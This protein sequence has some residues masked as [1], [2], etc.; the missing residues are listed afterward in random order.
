MTPAG[1]TNGANP[2]NISPSQCLINSNEG[3][4]GR[5]EETS[6]EV[7]QH[8]VKKLWLTEFCGQLCSS[9]ARICSHALSHDP[10]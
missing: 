5:A 4:G 8:T 10:S 9:L 3:L 6:Q 7:I 1:I 2:E